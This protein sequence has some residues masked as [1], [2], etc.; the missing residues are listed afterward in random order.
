MIHFCFGRIQLP[1]T[2]QSAFR[3]FLLTK[4]YTLIREDSQIYFAAGNIFLHVFFLGG[5]LRISNFSN[6][7][8]FQ[9]LEKPYHRVATDLENLEKSGNLKETSES[10]GICQKSQGICNRIP[11]VREFCC[12][13][14]IFSQVEDPNFENFLGE[15]A[16]RPPKWSWTHSRV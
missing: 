10:Q 9:A 5:I 15:Y 8:F 2:C 4:S 1:D 12:L 3:I 13:K 16:L 6:N 7:R 14:F 11:K